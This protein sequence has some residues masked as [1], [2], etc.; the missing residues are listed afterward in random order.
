M[1]LVNS[2]EKSIDDCSEYAY[3]V[4]NFT[5]GEVIDATIKRIDSPNCRLDTI[6]D[7]VKGPDFPT[8][9]IVEGKKE[10]EE[11]LTTGRG[12]VII[13]SKYEIIEDKKTKQILIH[14]IPFE[15]N[16][17]MLVKKIADIIYDKKIDGM[18]EIRD[19]SDREEK[20]RIAIDLKKDA[21]KELILEKVDSSLNIRI[22]HEIKGC[23]KNFSKYLLNPTN[24]FF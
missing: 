23:S 3:G 5:L 22:P 7:I 19:E 17:A 2:N 13:R 10:I 9:A 11:A 12:K 24:I 6:L 16:K 1:F 21:N 14:E 20:V 15:V 4:L 18:V 8:G